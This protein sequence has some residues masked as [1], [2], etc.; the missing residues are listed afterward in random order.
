M[1]VY[2]H[3]GTVTAVAVDEFSEI[4]INARPPPSVLSAYTNG[5]TVVPDI[6]D[7]TSERGEIIFVKLPKKKK[8]EARRAY[9]ERKKK[10]CARARDGN[11]T[12]GLMT[13]L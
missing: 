6:Y 9:V 12:L 10:R 13:S 7:S 3:I 8:I 1:R 11:S 4:A 2:S 5:K